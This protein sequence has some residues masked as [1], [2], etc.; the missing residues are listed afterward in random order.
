[1]DLTDV[2]A[3]FAL[4]RVLSRGRE[5]KLHLC[6]AQYGEF[7]QRRPTTDDF[8]DESVSR[9][10]IWLDGKMGRRTVKNRRADL[11]TLWRS[12]WEDGYVDRLPRRVRKVRVPVPD[13]HALSLP[14]MVLLIR[15]SYRLRG[16]FANSG[17][18][19][20]PLMRAWCYG[21]YDS[22]LRPGDQWRVERD[23]IPEDGFFMMP[24]S[25]TGQ[26]IDVQ[27]RPPT[28]AA[29][30]ESYPNN[31]PPRRRVFGDA[32]CYTHF[33]TTFLR[34]CELAGVQATPKTLRSTSGTWCN[35]VSPG[36]GGKH[37]G[38]KTNGIFERYYDDRKHYARN[39]P[40]P[41]ELPPID[42][43]A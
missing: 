30:A 40:M 20:G 36:S 25:K 13:P 22:G 21:A 37:L 35:V 24:Q 5:G 4:A 28:L 31:V 32:C 19:K 23:W 16:V 9:W 33:G 12:A 14:E 26:L 39:K 11:I 3:G 18:P 29:I 27:F 10:V 15:A 34:L 6:L 41:P 43:A 8:N 7:L 2:L 38:H 42:P 17:V 1:M